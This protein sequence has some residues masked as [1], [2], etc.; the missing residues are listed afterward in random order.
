M[1]RR[2]ELYGSPGSKKSTAPLRLTGPL[3]AS[4]TMDK[5][6]G[7]ADEQDARVAGRASQLAA[8]CPGLSR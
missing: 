5:G 3:K 1:I 4:D 6:D 2:I 7:Q 8:T